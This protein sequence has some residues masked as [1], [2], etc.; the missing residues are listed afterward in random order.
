MAGRFSSSYK[1]AGL[2]TDPFYDTSAGM[3]HGGANQ[4]LSSLTNGFLN[5]GV[6]YISPKVMGAVTVNA[7]IFLDNEDNSPNGL[8]PQSNP[9]NFGITYNAG[10]ITASVQHFTDADVNGEG[11]TR[12][13]FAYAANAFAVALSYEDWDSGDE[14]TYLSGSYKLSDNTKLAASFGDVDSQATA[15]QNM[16]GESITVGVYQKVAPQTTISLLFSDVDADSGGNDRQTAALGIIQ[17]F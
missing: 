7:A 11:A 4:G 10:G 8:D 14:F 6:S 15:G 9:K 1:M 12:G 2:K 16:A 13:T 5:N 3:G 17:T